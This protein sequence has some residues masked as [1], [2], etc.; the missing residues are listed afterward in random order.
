MSSLAQKHYMFRVFRGEG[1]GGFGQI[2]GSSCWKSRFG[3][4]L[5]ALCEQLHVIYGIHM[6]FFMGVPQNGWFIRENVIKMDDLGTPPFQ[7]TS[8]YLY[9]ICICIY[10]IR[11]AMIAMIVVAYSPCWICLTFVGLLSAWWLN[12]EQKLDGVC[13][14]YAEI[15]QGEAL[16]SD[17]NNV[18]SQTLKV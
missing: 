3:F 15:I 13:L 9:K 12:N 10:H 8:I 16:K 1:A 4:N 18:Y 11:I 6:G 17:V 2:L 7:E 5:V 14:V